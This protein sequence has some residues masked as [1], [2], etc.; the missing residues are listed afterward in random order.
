MIKPSRL[1]SLA[2]GI[3]TS[4]VDSGSRFIVSADGTFNDQEKSCFI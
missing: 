1:H 2:G 4:Q 3:F